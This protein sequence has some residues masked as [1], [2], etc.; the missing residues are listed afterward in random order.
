M[1]RAREILSVACLLILTGCVTPLEGQPHPDFNTELLLQLL[2]DVDYVVTNYSW[3][4][5]LL[6]L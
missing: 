4:L 5:V 2:N 3:L 6:G 1:A